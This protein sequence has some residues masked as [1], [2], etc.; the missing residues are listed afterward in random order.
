M[1]QL[2]ENN[3]YNSRFNLVHIVNVY[4]VKYWYKVNETIQ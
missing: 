3:L 1:L 4:L 2:F